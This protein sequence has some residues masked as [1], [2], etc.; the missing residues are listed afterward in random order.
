MSDSEQEVESKLKGILE[1]TVAY[2][3]RAQVN[4][5]EM[6]VNNRT[7]KELAAPPLD[8]QPLCIQYLPWRL[9]LSLSLE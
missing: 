7:L 6:A 5:E 1:F 3:A 2:R 9:H 8:Q 4:R